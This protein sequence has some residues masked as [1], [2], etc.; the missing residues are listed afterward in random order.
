MRPYF[1]LLVQSTYTT[2][3]NSM[4]VYS[5]FMTPLIH[6]YSCSYNWQAQV[7]ITPALPVCALVPCSSTLDL[8]STCIYIFLEVWK[9]EI[10][11]VSKT[12]T[13]KTNL[14]NLLLRISLIQSILWLHAI[15]FHAHS[16]EVSTIVHFW[17]VNES[18]GKA[19]ESPDVLW[20]A[21]ECDPKCT[22][23]SQSI[24]IICLVTLICNKS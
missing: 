4:F 13:V 21:Q 16:Y 9:K 10:A 1:F 12:L 2:G 8:N 5:F 22:A 19:W 11:H 3:S 15:S 14:E 20:L 23:S 18:S 17:R 6:H 24:E 7:I